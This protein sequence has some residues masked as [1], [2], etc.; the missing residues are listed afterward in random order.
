MIIERR[1]E[2]QEEVHELLL[3][4]MYS[5]DPRRDSLDAG[6]TAAQITNYWTLT[7]EQQN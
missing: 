7:T 1:A 6:T 4:M 3:M 2:R 5:V